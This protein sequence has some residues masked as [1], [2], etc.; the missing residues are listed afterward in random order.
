MCTASSSRR[1]ETRQRQRENLATAIAR[2][3]ALAATQAARDAA[4][5]RNDLN[6]ASSAA[7]SSA[8]AQAQLVRLSRIQPNGRIALELSPDRARSTSCPTCRWRTPTG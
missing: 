4:N 2:V 7:V 1:E 8:A 6:A 5:T 3:E